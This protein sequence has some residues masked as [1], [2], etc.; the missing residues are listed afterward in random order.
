M[1]VQTMLLVILVLLEGPQERAEP[2][3]EGKTWASPFTQVLLDGLQIILHVSLFIALTLEVLE[4]CREDGG[5]GG[6][7]L[8]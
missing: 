4:W 3:H 2:I 5:E 8:I 7:Q 6:Q 1:T